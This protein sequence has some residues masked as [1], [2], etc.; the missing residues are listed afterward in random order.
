MMAA[1]ERNH[2]TKPQ[3]AA[4][5]PHAQPER[6]GRTIGMMGA[7]LAAWLMLTLTGAMRVPNG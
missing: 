7:R 4:K 6:D 1:N 2:G 3:R 5:L